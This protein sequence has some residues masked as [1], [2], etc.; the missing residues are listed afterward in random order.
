M[1]KINFDIFIFLLLG[2]SL[3][4]FDFIIFEG[5]LIFLKVELK[6][7]YKI[8]FD[9]FYGLLK[10]EFFLIVYGWGIKV[11]VKLIDFMGKVI[12]VWLNKGRNINL[13]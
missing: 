6:V 4:D 10:W 7:L 3:N 5:L 12:K 2:I 9:G 11:W 1:E 8:Y 13:I